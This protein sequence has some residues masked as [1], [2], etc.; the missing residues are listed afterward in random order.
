M[1]DYL[2]YEYSNG[3]EKDIENYDIILSPNKPRYFKISK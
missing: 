2:K 1:L 3:D